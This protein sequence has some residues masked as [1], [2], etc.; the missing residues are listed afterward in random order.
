MCM[1]VWALLW[2]V[3]VV[4]P[5][6]S[7]LACF[8]RFGEYYNAITGMQEEVDTEDTGIE[9]SKII[10]VRSPPVAYTHT[11]LH[12]VTLVASQLLYNRAL[13]VMSARCLSNSTGC[14]NSWQS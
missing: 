8:S 9:P 5:H 11:T 12:P 4:T 2:A 13:P 7:P 6:H 10:S 1:C 3:L 14:S